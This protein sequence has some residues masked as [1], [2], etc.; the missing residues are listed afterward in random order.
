MCYGE[1]KNIRGK[2]ID[3][4]RSSKNY[5]YDIAVM[6]ARLIHGDGAEDHIGEIGMAGAL[7]VA[8]MIQDIQ[9][10]LNAQKKKD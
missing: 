7:H 5:A 3:L 4:Y 8:Q 1:C 10:Y 2:V 6:I 9:G